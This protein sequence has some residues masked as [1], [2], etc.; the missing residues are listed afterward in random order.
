[1]VEHIRSGG[2]FW[3]G[4]YLS[5][6]P[7]VFSNSS[8]INMKVRTPSVGVPVLLKL[9]QATGGKVLFNCKFNSC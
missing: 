9:E 8:I 3:A 5:V 4:T 1:M 7:I 2:Q 6:E